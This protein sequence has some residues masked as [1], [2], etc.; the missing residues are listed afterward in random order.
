MRKAEE[1]SRKEREEEKIRTRAFLAIFV[2]V[3]I[4]SFENV[5][6]KLRRYEMRSPWCFSVASKVVSGGR[7]E[8]REH[9]A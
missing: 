8:G 5:A 1:F 9:L 3:R 4:R 7:S 6:D 2:G